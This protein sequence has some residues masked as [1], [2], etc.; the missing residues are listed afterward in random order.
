MNSVARGIRR[1]RCIIGGF[2]GRRAGRAWAGWMRGQE[3][4]RYGLS[5]ASVARGCRLPFR[6]AD[7]ST[8]EVRTERLWQVSSS[9]TPPLL[10]L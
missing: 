4:G 7:K 1:G 10:R 3:R 8:Q 5:T 9:A 2:A 6:S